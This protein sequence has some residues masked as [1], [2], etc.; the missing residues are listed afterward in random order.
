MVIERLGFVYLKE[1]ALLEIKVANIQQILDA[2]ILVA[3]LSIRKTGR[4]DKRDISYLDVFFETQVLGIFNLFIESM[5]DVR[6]KQ[7]IAEKIRTLKAIEE[8]VRLAK[9]FISG[10]LP[11]VIY[12]WFLMIPYLFICLTDVLIDNRLFTIGVGIRTATNK[13]FVCLECYDDNPT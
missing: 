7:P 11:Q 3:S 9:G 10:A 8:M 12:W 1:T 6:V 4:R 2:L 5:K 13:C